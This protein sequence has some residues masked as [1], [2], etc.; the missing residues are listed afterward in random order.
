MS[1]TLLLFSSGVLCKNKHPD[2][3]EDVQAAKN[4]CVGGYHQM[5]SQMSE[6]NFYTG[7]DVEEIRSVCQ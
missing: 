6:D 2:C 1:L 5:L 4:M 7:V 3:G